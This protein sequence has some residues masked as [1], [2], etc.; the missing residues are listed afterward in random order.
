MLGSFTQFSDDSPTVQ[1]PSKISFEFLI[2][3]PNKLFFKSFIREQNCPTT[4]R[5]QR[6]GVLLCYN[7]CT[8]TLLSKLLRNNV[9][10]KMALHISK[11]CEFVS[12]ITNL[13]NPQNAAPNPIGINASAILTNLCILC[14]FTVPLNF[15]L[16]YKYKKMFLSYL[17]SF[18]SM[19]SNS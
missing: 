13:I 19:S 15:T 14:P 8:K 4:E 17:N 5:E 18:F 9:L 2:R 16:C 12:D 3:K 7:N 6:T 1:E 11:R 10:Y